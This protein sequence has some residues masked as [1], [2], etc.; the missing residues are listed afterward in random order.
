MS[1]MP[2]R[3]AW[4]VCSLAIV[5]AADAA[6]SSGASASDSARSGATAQGDRQ[7]AAQSGPAKPLPTVCDRKI[8]TPDDVSDLLA[9]PIA[10][11]PLP[12]DPQSCVFD[13][14]SFTSITVSVR[15]GLGD[16][17]VGEWISGKVPVPGVTVS[18]IGDKAVWQDTLRELIATKHNVLCDIQATG[19]NGSAADVQK[20]FAALCGK[21]WA[22]Q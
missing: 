4:F 7:A 8:V 13:G 6:C 22:A 21:I 20:K 1:L 10:S 11:K 19:A 17:S 2:G 15:P 9:G 14:A 16:I 18:G 3:L 5:A 12:G